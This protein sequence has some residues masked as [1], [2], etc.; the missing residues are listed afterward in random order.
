MC[1]MKTRLAFIARKNCSINEIYL[2]LGAR[3]LYVRFFLDPLFDFLL[4]EPRLDFFDL[5]FDFRLGVFL[6]LFFD[7]DL[8]TDRRFTGDFAILRV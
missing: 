1:E 4:V 6:E 2:R 7:R 3:L 5:L 8:D